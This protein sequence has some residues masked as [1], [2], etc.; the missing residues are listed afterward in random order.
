MRPTM[1]AITAPRGAVLRAAGWRVAAP[2]A[3]GWRVAAPRVAA[4]RAALLGVA[5]LRAAVLVAA[6]LGLALSACS[7]LAPRP[8]RSRYYVLTPAAETRP[9]AAAVTPARALALGVGPV[10][11]PDYL[12]R[13]EIAT[14]VEAYRIERSA[15]D[16]WAEPLETAIPRVLAR[17]LAALVGPT[18][19]VLHPWYT[20]ARP[21][22]QVA[23]DVQRFERTAGGDVELVARW[24]VTPLGGRG[25]ARSGESRIAEPAGG[26]ME[27]AVAAQSRAL[28]RLAAEIAA[29]LAPGGK[30][31]TGGP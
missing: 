26:D 19:L 14:R 12:R 16:Y 31:F 13:P 18:R 29:V 28:A 17:D 6:V 24:T 22:V 7:P 2:R 3:A 23:V 25:A 30:E 21:D 5:P 10:T 1:M 8:D 9:E 4:V 20:S 11:I 15:T 27:A